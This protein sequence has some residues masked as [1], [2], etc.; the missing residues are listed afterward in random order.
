MDIKQSY[1]DNLRK[2][3]N[4]YGDVSVME[5]Q[6]ALNIM[7][8]YCNTWNLSVNPAKSKLVIFSKSNYSKEYVFMYHGNDLDVDTDFSYLG[9][10][11]DQ[12]DNF[13]KARSRI[14]E[15]ARRA[16]FAVNSKSS[17]QSVPVDLQLKLFDNMIALMARRCEGMRTVI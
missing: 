12:K 1:N 2:L 9:M 17:Q 14:I 15:Q 10:T 4:E 11:F 13:F 3:P 16:S 5:L 8:L 6:A 7:F